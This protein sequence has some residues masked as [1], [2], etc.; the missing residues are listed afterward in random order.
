[1][2]KTEVE[3]F[4]NKQFENVRNDVAVKA[5]KG[6]S[7]ISCRLCIFSLFL[8]FFVWSVRWLLSPFHNSHP[9]MDFRFVYGVSHCLCTP[10]FIGAQVTSV[11][12]TSHFLLLLFRTSF[13]RLFFFSSLFPVINAMIDIIQHD[14]NAR[15]IISLKIMAFQQLSTAFGFHNSQVFTENIQRQSS[16]SITSVYII[17]Q[18]P[19]LPS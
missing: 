18:R 17:V 2:S 12:S 8:F 4:L 19:N 13:W 5:L 6:A 11:S 15:T 10:I 9:Q 3:N 7:L 1:M 16:T 14:R